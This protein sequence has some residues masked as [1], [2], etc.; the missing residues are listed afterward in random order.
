MCQH[1]WRG[2]A[3]GVECIKCGATMTAQEY[4]DSLKKD[5]PPE[6]PKKRGRKA[7]KTDE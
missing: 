3:T 1:E 6:E 4:I 2:T 5:P 7:V